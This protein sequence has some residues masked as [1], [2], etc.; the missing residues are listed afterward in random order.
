MSGSNAFALLTLALVA[1]QYVR[2]LIGGPVMAAILPVAMAGLVVM[3][4]V[5]LPKVKPLTRGLAGGLAA[6]SVLLL[7]TG[8]P[9]SALPAGLTDALT[10]AAYLPI[11]QLLRGV[12]GYLPAMMRAKDRFATLPKSASAAGFVVGAYGV[13]IIITTGAHAVL[14]PLLASN[15]DDEER[16]R[17]ALA[18]LRG[19]SLTAFWSPFA[20]AVAFGAHNVP[21]APVWLM[22]LL[23]LGFATLGVFIAVAMEGGGRGLGLA[24][25]GLVPILPGTAI[26]ALA[27]VVVS[28]FAN[29]SGLDAVI[30]VMPPLSILALLWQARSSLRPALNQVWQNIGRPSDE[31]LLMPMALVLGH[32]IEAQPG[33]A[34]SLAPFLEGLPVP[35]LLALAM[36]ALIGF[37]MIGLHPMVSAASIVAL[38]AGMPG[39]VSQIAL[40]QAILIAWGFATMLSPSGVTLIVAALAYRVPYPKLSFSKNILFALIVCSIA[41]VCLSLL[42]PVVRTLVR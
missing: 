25:Q 42:D 33:L 34:L 15:A 24:L 1:S 4:I 10:F 2:L 13:G 37:G 38:F 26:G 23:G 7:L 32:L 9:L 5:A 39:A 18:S 21:G 12:A 36:G 6:V 27:V 19:V 31:A 40:L 28:Y 14:A 11:L 41:V 16:R 20:V 8:S 3:G 29:V 30:L 22:L 17:A 35:V